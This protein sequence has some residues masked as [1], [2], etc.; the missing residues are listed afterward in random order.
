MR[1]HTRISERRACSLIGL[2]RSALH[3][4]P[5]VQPANE[6]LQARLVELAQQRRRFGY[7]RPHILLHRE[8]VEVNHKRIHR[9]YREAG[10]MVCKRE[11]ERL[12]LPER[13]RGNQRN[14][15]VAVPVSALTVNARR[16]AETAHAIIRTSTT[17]GVRPITT[18]RQ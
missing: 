4:P 10:L 2:S 7:R 14:I 5:R 3:Y 11:R 9:L 15:I 13:G 12:S 18:I 1:E 16:A 17:A 8:D 6:A